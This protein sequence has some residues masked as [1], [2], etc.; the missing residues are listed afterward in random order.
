[1]NPVTQA[2]RFAAGI[3]VLCGLIAR[4]GLLRRLAGPLIVLIWQRVRT[5]G[6]QVGALLAQ[7]QASPP[8]RHLNRR[9]P[10]PGATPRRPATRSTLPNTTAW[11][12]ALI[13]ETAASAAHLK[14][15]LADPEVPA[16]LATAPQLRRKLRPLCRMLGVRLPP[17]ARPALSP[18]TLPPQ[19][20]DERSPAARLLR[21]S[22]VSTN[23]PAHGWA[24]A[25][26]P[27]WIACAADC[28]PFRLE[29]PAIP[30]GA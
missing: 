24:G 15:L 7:M 27:S 8:R 28:A 20:P 18:P 14:L 5:V 23:V 3:D 16:L 22:A 2:D 19:A 25:N 1:M 26:Q 12:V 4:H 30:P 13:P 6:T 21:P 17:Q 29:K 9:S 10:R 11:L